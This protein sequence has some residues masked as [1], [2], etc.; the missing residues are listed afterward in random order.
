MA[1]W[2]FGLVFLSAT[3]H[4]LWNLMV[5][6]SHNKVSFA[7][8]TSLVGAAALFPVF[9]AGRLAAPGPLDAEIW[10]LALWSSLFQALYVI[11]LF[12]AYKY[13]DL[14]VVYPLSRGAAPL[15]TLLLGDALLGD[16]VSPA[17]VLAVTVIAAGVAL[18]GCS[19]RGAAPGR[20][21]W[22]GASLAVGVG[23]AI[24]GYHL[25]DRAV[26]TLPRPPQPWEYLFLMQVFLA[27]WVALWAAIMLRKKGG[28]FSEWRANA[29]GVLLVGSFTPLAYLLIVLALKYGNVTHVAAGRNV[30]IL[31][32][33]LAG[34]FFLKER[35]TATRVWGLVLIAVGVVGLVFLPH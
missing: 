33:A 26:M 31:L 6:T 17:G 5:K 12:S 10:R 15:F 7:W 11:L 4:V 18:V 14:S 27:L 19:A 21:D 22:R 16:S 23:A 2:V 29:R 24:A 13:A 34:A 20:F 9:L 35:L 25:V 32:S 28:L 1:S 30:G 3:L 8:L